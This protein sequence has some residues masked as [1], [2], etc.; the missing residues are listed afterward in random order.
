MT[1]FNTICFI[2]NIKWSQNPSM[3]HIDFDI[4]SPSYFLT[5]QLLIGLLDIFNLDTGSYKQSCTVC[6]I[7]I[8]STKYLFGV[9]YATCVTS[10]DKQVNIDRLQYTCTRLRSLGGTVRSTDKIG[11]TKREKPTNGQMFSFSIGR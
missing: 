9:G 6:I 10:I 3:V 4:A 11:V 7:C 8:S 2:K 5:F 1:G